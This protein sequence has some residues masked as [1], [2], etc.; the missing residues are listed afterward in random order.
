MIVPWSNE[1]ERADWYKE[2]YLKLLDEISETTMN[3][4]SDE[5]DLQAEKLSFRIREIKSSQVYF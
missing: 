4:I 2:R 1:T 5:T 3:R